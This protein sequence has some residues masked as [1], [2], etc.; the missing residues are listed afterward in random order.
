MTKT[1]TRVS[2]HIYE[3]PVFHVTENGLEQ[4]DSESIQFCKGSRRVPDHQGFITETLLEL[5]RV[6]LESVNQGELENKFTTEAIEHIRLALWNL[7]ERQKDRI[8]RDVAQ[9]YEK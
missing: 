4:I 9:T 5:C 1:I 6:H 2:S 3:L 8:K 7:E